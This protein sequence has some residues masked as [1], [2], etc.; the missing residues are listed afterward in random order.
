MGKV[1]AIDYGMVRIGLAISDATKTIAFPLKTIQAAPSLKK[2]AEN[3]SLAIKDKLAEIDEMVIGYPLLLTGKR[4]DMAKRVE[5]LKKEL[6]KIFSFPITLFDERLT[7]AMAERSLK[8]K[9]FSRKKR[10]KKT[11]PIAAF[12]ILQTYLDS[13]RKDAS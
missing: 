3:I 6:E 12:F 4:G 9:G 1:I 2:T 13:R 10:S 8:E 5:E 7:S 11:D